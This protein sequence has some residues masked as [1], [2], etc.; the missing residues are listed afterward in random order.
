MHFAIRER[1]VLDGFASE[2]FEHANIAEYFRA[3]LF[4][5]S[6]LSHIGVIA[7]VSTNDNAAIRKKTNLFRS[8]WTQ[9][10]A[11]FGIMREYFL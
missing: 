7:C 1:K 2:C 11:K 10:Q 4:R 3:N 8:V 5:R 6:D 9:V